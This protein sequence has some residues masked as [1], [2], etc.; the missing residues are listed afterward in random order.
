MFQGPQACITPGW[1]P[2][3]AEHGRVVPTWNDV[4][5]HVNGVDLAQRRRTSP[6]L[7]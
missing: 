1:Y 4:V 2:G 5:A 7:A 6:A 3:T